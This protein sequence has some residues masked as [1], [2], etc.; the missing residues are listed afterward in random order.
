MK[1]TKSEKIFGDDQMAWFTGE[2][3]IIEA[4]D[5]KCKI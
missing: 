5:K 1:D 2:S 4:L 3:S